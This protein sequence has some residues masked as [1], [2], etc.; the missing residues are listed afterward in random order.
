MGYSLVYD[1]SRIPQGPM[2]WINFPVTVWIQYLPWIMHSSRFVVVGSGSV[3]IYFY[4]ELHRMIAQC[5][6]SNPNEYVN[7]WQDYIGK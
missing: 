4:N 3:L 1:Y 7:I 2:G 6:R 5:Q